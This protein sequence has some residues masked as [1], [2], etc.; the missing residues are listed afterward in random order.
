MSDPMTISLS[1]RAAALLHPAAFHDPAVVAVNPD[2]VPKEH[3]IYGWWFDAAP[4]GV[5]AEGTIEVDGRR[6]LY[7]GICPNGSNPL[8]ERSLRHRMKEHCRGPIRSSTLRR[9]LVALLGDHLALRV[10]RSPRSKLILEGD[11]E[12]RLSHWMHEHLRVA[13]MVHTQPWTL[14]TE[15]IHSIRLP[16]NI[17]GSR[18]PDRALMDRRKLLGGLGRS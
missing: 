2:L 15:L 13:W 12:T 10:V 18:N 5:S 8:S 1:E 7:V 16:L 4:P 14:E 11:G 17:M 6:L 3:G 9:T